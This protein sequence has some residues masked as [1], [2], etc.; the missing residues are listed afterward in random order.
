MV[1]TCDNKI[2][3]IIKKYSAN[4]EIKKGTENPLF[5]R[6]LIVHCDIEED[7]LGSCRVFIQG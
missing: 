6:Y 3:F 7:T 5:E 1:T 2:M 4:N